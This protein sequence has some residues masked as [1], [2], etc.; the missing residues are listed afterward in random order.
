MPQMA[1]L[2]WLTLMIMFTFIIML[3]N[4]MNFYIF[5]YQPIKMSS[6]KKSNMSWKW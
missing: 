2:N 5:K 6:L 1:P 4:C 3:T